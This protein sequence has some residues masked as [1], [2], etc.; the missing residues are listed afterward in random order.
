ML[1]SGLAWNWVEVRGGQNWVALSLGNVRDKGN[2]CRV[3]P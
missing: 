1:R 3:R 2:Q